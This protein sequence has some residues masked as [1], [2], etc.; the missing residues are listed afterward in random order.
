[1]QYVFKQRLIHFLLV[2]AEFFL[3]WS[4][5]LLIVMLLML[6]SSCSTYSVQVTNNAEG[7]HFKRDQAV[8]PHHCKQNEGLKIMTLNIAH[9]RKEAFNQLF[10]TADKIKR[11]L[12]DI[13]E[14]L[15]EQCADV[16]ALQEADG[17]SGWS[18]AKQA[19]YPWYY[20]ADHAQSWLFSYGTAVLSRWPISETVEHTFTPS[21]P[22]LNKGFLLSKLTW[23]AP[24]ENQQKIAVDIVSVH[25]DF[26]RKKVRK[27]QIMEIAEVLNKRNNPMI[28]LGDFNSDWFA[29]ESVVKQLAQKTKMKVYKPHADNL[30]TYAKRATRLDWI[31]ISDELEF[32]SYQVIP[33]V[34]SDHLAVVAEIK[35]IK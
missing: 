17:P 14:V 23:K 29:E 5:Q 26:S 11:N 2:E 12:T 34:I 9:G 10:V 22:T 16:V 1:M 30:H 24:T 32:T 28:V 4:R 18:G 13:V 8:N 31:L 35:L 7:Q 15:I 6:V 33:D 27:Q 19:G 21:P 25:L 3:S 20:R